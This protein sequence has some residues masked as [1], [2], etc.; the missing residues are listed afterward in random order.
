LRGAAGASSGEEAKGADGK[1]TAA[2]KADGR[3]AADTKVSGAGDSKPA[4]K[5]GKDNDKIIDL[6]AAK[7]AGR[8][9]SKRR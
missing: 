4:T 5:G 1:A 3:G 7:A 9:A 6:N 2:A 8:P